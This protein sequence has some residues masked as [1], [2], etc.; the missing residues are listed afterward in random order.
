MEV[1]F[2]A[3]FILIPA[4]AA[5]QSGW[6]GQGFALP[7]ATMP[8]S[9]RLLGNNK[10]V[11]PYYLAPL[12]SWLAFLVIYQTPE[13]WQE[14]VAIGLGVVVGEHLKSYIK[15]RLGYGPGE[16]WFPDK[17]DFALGAGVAALLVYPW[18]TV[19]H[20]GAIVLLAIP[21]HFVGNRVG[22]AFGWRKTPH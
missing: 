13:E 18:F 4:L 16:A 21:V 11:A 22:F 6:V 17:F 7:L 1:I 10:T 12:L 20:L 2:G 8:V 14:A 15:R 9:R 5:N 19:V 3:F